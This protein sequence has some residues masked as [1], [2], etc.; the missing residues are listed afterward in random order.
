[1]GLFPNFTKFYLVTTFN[2][3]LRHIALYRNIKW[4][5]INIK[6]IKHYFR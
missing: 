5:F 6:Y 4:C 1:M 3:P 2:T